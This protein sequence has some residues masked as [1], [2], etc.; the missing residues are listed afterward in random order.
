MTTSKVTTSRTCE[1]FIRWRVTDPGISLIHRDGIPVKSRSLSY[2]AV[3][4]MGEVTPEFLPRE[5]S[6]VNPPSLLMFLL[7]DCEENILS[8]VNHII[9]LASTTIPALV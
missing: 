9:A 2:I 3:L 5:I 7:C 8:R 4:G 6:E 1:A